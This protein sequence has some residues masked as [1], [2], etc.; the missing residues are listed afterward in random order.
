MAIGQ[1][2]RIKGIDFKWLASRS[3]KGGSGFSNQDNMIYVPL[4]TAQHFLLGKRILCDGNR[5]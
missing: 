5:C 2:I 3:S 1:T 4:S